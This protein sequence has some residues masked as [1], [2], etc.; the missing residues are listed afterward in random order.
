MRAIVQQDTASAARA[1]IGRAR[2]VAEAVPVVYD[3][4][5]VPPLNERLCTA[6]RLVE[7]V[8][9]RHEQQLSRAA[10]GVHHRL[11][12]GHRFRQRLL[13]EDAHARCQHLFGDLPVVMRGRE[14]AHGIQPF[15]LNHLHVAGVGGR[16]RLGGQSGRLCLVDIR[17]GNDLGQAAIL[18]RR[19]VRA[20]DPAA[21]NQPYP[22]LVRHGLLLHPKGLIA[23]KLRAPI[24]TPLPPAIAQK[25]GVLFDLRGPGHRA[26]APE[27]QFIGNRLRRER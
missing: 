25:A 10:R 15:L 18:I 9:L 26:V 22:E 3:A 14:Q 6:H 20:G 16:L 12:I 4:P 5:E 19:Q 17:N 24:V 1:G 13:R 21:T 27:H 23:F 11:G 7:A 8:A 2:E